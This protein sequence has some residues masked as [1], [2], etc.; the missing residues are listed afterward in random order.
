MPTAEDLTDPAAFL[1]ADELLDFSAFDDTQA[2]PEGGVRD[3]APDDDD[4]PHE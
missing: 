4:G 3:D 1:V 2:P